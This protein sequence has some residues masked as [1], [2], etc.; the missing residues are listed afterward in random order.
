M[1]DTDIVSGGFFLTRILE[2]PPGLG[3]GTLPDRILTLS[4]CLTELFPDAWAVE[5][6]LIPEADRIAAAAKVGIGESALPDVLRYMTAAIAGE[7]LDVFSVWRSLAAARA[8]ASTFGLDP[9]AF[10]IVELG[11]QAGDVDDLLADLAPG[12]SE[13]AMGIYLSL[14]E[15]R[16]LHENGVLAG[17][18]LLGAESGGD[19]HSWL[20]NSLQNEAA[21]Q[22]GISPGALGLLQ[23]AE[24][25]RAVAALIASGI[26]AEPVPWF[27]AQLVRHE[28][29]PD[30]QQ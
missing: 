8:A 30:H 14:R 6:V 7:T 2:R 28:W 24:D 26:G 23:S 27:A 17:W 9:A 13:G 25:A 22:L 1:R 16:P 4:S 20:C 15:R 12:P 3:D 5:W 21:R 10:A 18:E 11:V 19:F 29:A